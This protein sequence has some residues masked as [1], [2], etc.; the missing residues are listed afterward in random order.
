MRGS[1]RSPFADFR[2]LG[3]PHFPYVLSYDE[4]Y[5]KN[6]IN[7]SISQIL[8]RRQEKTVK[9]TMKDSFINGLKIKNLLSR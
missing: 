2:V 8:S 4:G 3:K 6:R 9:P 7:G 1:P 5:M